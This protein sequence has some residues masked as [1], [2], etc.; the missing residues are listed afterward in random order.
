MVNILDSADENKLKHRILRIQNLGLPIAVIAGPLAV[1]DM[2]LYD[3]VIL[4]PGIDPAVPLVQSRRTGCLSRLASPS[5]KKAALLSSS[6]GIDSMSGW[7]ASAKTSGAERDPGETTARRSPR[8]ASVSTRTPLQS[9][10]TFRESGVGMGGADE[11]SN[12][13]RE[14][15]PQK[16]GSSASCM[17]PNFISVSAISRSDEEPATIPAPA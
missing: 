3:R 12:R 8:R 13:G 2:T 6:T 15:R 16:P 17:A 7:R 11:R 10:F 1:R 9:E 4:S 14:C 5:A